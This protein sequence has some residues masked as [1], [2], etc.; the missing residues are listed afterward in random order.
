VRFSLVRPNPRLVSGCDRCAERASS[1]IASGRHGSGKRKPRRKG[2]ISRR[3]VWKPRTKRG[4]QIPSSTVREGRMG[5]ETD[6]INCRIQS[7]RK[8][9]VRGS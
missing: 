2:K 7:G 4:K 9:L 1:A 5:N 3:G 6:G 8:R